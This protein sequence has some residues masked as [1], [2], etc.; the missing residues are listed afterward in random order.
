MEYFS[1]TCSTML[2]NLLDRAEESHSSV[3]REILWKRSSL[4]EISE[5][6]KSDTAK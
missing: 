4:P 5:F 6:K 2:V 1:Y 3:I